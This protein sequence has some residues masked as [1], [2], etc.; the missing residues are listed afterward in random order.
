MFYYQQPS[1]R[2]IEVDEIVSEDFGNYDLPEG[3]VIYY[4]ENGEVVTILSGNKAAQAIMRP[5]IEN[6]SDVMRPQ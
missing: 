6:L 2:H 4:E 5:L 1:R 3:A